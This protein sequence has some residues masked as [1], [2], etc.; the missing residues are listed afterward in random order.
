MGWRSSDMHAV[1]ASIVSAL[2]IAICAAAPEFVWQGTRIALHNPTWT[3][4]VG[5]LLMGMVLAFFVEPVMDRARR[6]MM[7]HPENE[8]PPRNPLATAGLALAFAV[9]SVCLHDA[10]ATFVAERGAAPGEVGSGIADAIGLATAWAIVPSAVTLAWLSAGSWRLHASLLVVAALSPGVAGW[11]FSWS[12][13]NIITTELPCAA[14]LIL[15]L[16]ET[17]RRLEGNPFPACARVVA[18][19]SVSWLVLAILIDALHLVRPPLYVSDEFW[20][21]VRFYLGWAIGLMVAPFPHFSREAH[22]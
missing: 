13:T 4:L 8:A 5:A 3:E 20:I 15:G 16:R 17:V 18:I 1:V 9:T 19:V 6:A 10:I 11:L 21:D 14:I 12:W 22:A 2:W 7:R